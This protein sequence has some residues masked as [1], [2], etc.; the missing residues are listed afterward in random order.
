[1]SPT[2]QVLFEMTTGLDEIFKL[3]EEIDH[4]THAFYESTHDNDEASDSDTERS[5]SDLD[6]SDSDNS[7]FYTT[8]KYNDDHLDYF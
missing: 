5:E 2:K 6:T 7:V 3:G 8:R 1:M 4:A